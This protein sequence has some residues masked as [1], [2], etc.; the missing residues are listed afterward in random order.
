MI[1][2]QGLEEKNFA[3]LNKGKDITKI[4]NYSTNTRNPPY[5]RHTHFA[6]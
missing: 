2:R 6:S 4:L 1:A 3:I 5:M